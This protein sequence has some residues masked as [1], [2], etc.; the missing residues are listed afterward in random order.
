MSRRLGD[1]VP[2]DLRKKLCAE[3]LIRLEGRG[4]L[5]LS[6]DES[7]FPHPAMLSYREMASPD[8]SR[9]RFALWKGTT[10]SGNIRRD[11]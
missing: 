6:L 10:T 3:D 5:L 4:M 8:A 1:Q 11:P 7:G 2:D 9:I